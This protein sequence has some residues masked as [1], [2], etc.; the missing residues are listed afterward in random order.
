MIGKTFLETLGSS[1]R[2]CS[3]LGFLRRGLA[4]SADGISAQALIHGRLDASL[5]LWS[6]LLLLHDLLC[7]LRALGLLLHAFDSGIKVLG[8]VS[9]YC[10]GSGLWALRRT[11][12]TMPSTQTCAGRPDFC[13][14]ETQLCKSCGWTAGIWDGRT[15][16]ATLGLA[17][18]GRTAGSEGG[19]SGDSNQ[20]MV[21]P[22]T[23]SSFSAT[24]WKR[25]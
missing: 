15:S 7:G 4:V 11:M 9:S 12:G 22:S 18:L 20:G 23:G 19:I 8:Y 25:L 21:T 10:R 13:A 24:T 17:L 14:S 1:E 3:L 6:D 16:P 2:Y 5:N